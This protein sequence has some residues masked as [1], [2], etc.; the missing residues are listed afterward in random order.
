[1]SKAGLIV[2]STCLIVMAVYFLCVYMYTKEEP[3]PLTHEQVLQ[4]YQVDF[5]IKKVGG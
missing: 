3:K 5:G 2:G 1:M 4:S